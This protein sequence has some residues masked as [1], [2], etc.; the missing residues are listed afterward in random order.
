MVQLALSTQGAS[1]DS[2]PVYL[3]TPSFEHCLSEDDLAFARSEQVESGVPVSFTVDGQAVDI[4][5]CQMQPKGTPASQMIRYFHFA[6][7][8]AALIAKAT[9]T[10]PVFDATCN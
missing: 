3:I 10:T 9:K 2:F 1:M 4:V 7:D 8:T 6:M 5:T